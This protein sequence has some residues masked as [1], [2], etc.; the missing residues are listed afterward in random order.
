MEGS[1]FIMIVMRIEFLFEQL[2]IL[3]INKYIYSLLETLQIK[4]R[5]HLLE[6]LA[7]VFY[8]NYSIGE[9]K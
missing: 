2:K 7:I 6:F 4:F 8:M 5:I 9:N 3:V 1:L